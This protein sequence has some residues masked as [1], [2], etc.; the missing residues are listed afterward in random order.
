MS[1]LLILPAAIAFC[2][3][4]ALVAGIFSLRSGKE[5]RLIRQLDAKRQELL[6]SFRV[7]I[8]ESGFLKRNVGGHDFYVPMLTVLV[9]NVSNSTLEN[10][11]I[12]ADFESEGGLSCQSSVRLFH[13]GPGE[14]TEAALKCIEPT[15]FGSVVTGV[16]LSGTIQP[17]SFSVRVHHGYVYATVEQGK[18]TFKLLGTTLPL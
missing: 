14:T 9:S 1:Y 12:I 8:L 7:G 16:P 11:D 2:A 17:V 6:A 3:I 13:L 4:V 15:G 5:I 18:S 10:I